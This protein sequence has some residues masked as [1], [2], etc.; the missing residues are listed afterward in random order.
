M[1]TIYR[2]TTRSS[3]NKK[4]SPGLAAYRISNHMKPK[5]GGRTIELRLMKT[6]TAN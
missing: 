6:S 5:V 4:L 2:G 1:K 3:L